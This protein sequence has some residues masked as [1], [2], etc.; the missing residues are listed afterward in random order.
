MTD[1]IDLAPPQGEICPQCSRILHREIRVVSFDTHV[2]VD[3]DSVVALEPM[4][5]GDWQ[6]LVEQIAMIRDSTRASDE[7]LKN[8]DKRDAQRPSTSDIVEM[9]EKLDRNLATVI[10]RLDAVEA[11]LT[12][13][14]ETTP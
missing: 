7:R 3:Q 8:R 11:I 12:A 1:Q 6:S 10:S 14:K 9:L 4:P 5:A 13:P 2:C